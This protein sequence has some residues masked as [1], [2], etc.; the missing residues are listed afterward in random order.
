MKQIMLVLA[1]GCAQQADD[2]CDAM[3]AEA[4]EVY[5]HCLEDWD[6]DWNAAG[7]SDEADFIDACDT[8]VWEMRLIAEE[9]G[10]ADTV[11][12]TCTERAERFSEGQCNDFTD[13]DWNDMPWETSSGD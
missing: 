3:C 9:H 13:I 11:D 1:L 4:A 2:P 10:D 5:T 12:A 6:A 7:Y 8:W